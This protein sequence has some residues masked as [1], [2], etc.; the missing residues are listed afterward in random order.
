MGIDFR[1]T[2]LG[3]ANPLIPSGDDISYDPVDLQDATTA[4]Q[5]ANAQE[6]RFTRRN[7]Y[8]GTR[9]YVGVV[10]EEATILQTTTGDSNGL[11]SGLANIFQIGAGSD[12]TYVKFKIHCKEIHAAL[13]DP[14]DFARLDRITT[15]AQ[16]K[17]AISEAIIQQHDHIVAKIKN[18][19]MPKFGDIVKIKFA[20]G[21]DGGKQQEAE[22]VEI[23]SSNNI[24]S[25]KSFCDESLAQK[26]GAQTEVSAPL[27]EYPQSATDAGQNN[28][29][30]VATPVGKGVS[31]VA[32]VL[33]WPFVNGYKSRKKGKEIKYSDVGSPPSSYRALKN[34]SHNGCDFRTGTGVRILASADGIVDLVKNDNS[35]TGGGTRVRIRHEKGLT[36][37]N[38]L[39][40]CYMHFV[41]NSIPANIKQG[42]R[43]FRGQF[44]GLSNSTGGV[45]A[46]HLH[47]EV[48]RDL[49]G[50]DDITVK[51]SMSS[52]TKRK[53]QA[54]FDYSVIDPRKVL[55]LPG[56][57]YTSFDDSQRGTTT[58]TTNQ[59]S[60][61]P[62]TEQ[63]F[64]DEE[65]DLGESSAE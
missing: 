3:F 12:N 32:I 55:K 15:D 7:V 60:S 48:R 61:E 36:N 30:D 46:P 40:T 6:D 16:Y 59:S 49:R 56:I 28:S 38:P 31:D 27:S 21:P 53:Q 50:F 41:Y 25:I 58:T 52:A 33:S 14:C 5:I 65:P 43:V 18:N 34:R 11:F 13:P 51:D 44:L 54:N 35:R 42:Q 20:K 57:E 2:K 4:N 22:L 24:E 9:E 10:I 1:K 37:G 63:S 45:T 23:L 64:P 26:F 47:F 17:Q 62:N 19:E 39:Y 29:S 8:K